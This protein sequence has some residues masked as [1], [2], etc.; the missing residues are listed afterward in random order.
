[1]EKTEATMMK[2]VLPLLD[3]MWEGSPLVGGCKSSR[4]EKTDF[5]KPAPAMFNICRHKE[6]ASTTITM[7]LDF[8][9]FDY[10]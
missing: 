5:P 2:S 8:Y 3:Y 4:V 1:M 7:I 6:S 9:I 10:K